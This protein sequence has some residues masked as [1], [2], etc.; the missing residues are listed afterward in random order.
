MILVPKGA[1]ELNRAMRPAWVVFEDVQNQELGAWRRDDKRCVDDGD[2]DGT[3]KEPRVQLHDVSVVPDIL[4][5]GGFLEVDSWQAAFV[6]IRIRVCCPLSCRRKPRRL[7]H[8]LPP[9]SSP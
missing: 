6:G 1:D 2:Q 8:I 5:T 3:G 7:R 4:N 9:G